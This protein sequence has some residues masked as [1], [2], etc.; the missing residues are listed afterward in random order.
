M[1]PILQIGAMAKHGFKGNAALSVPCGLVLSAGS[2]EGSVP[3]CREII[4]CMCYPK[5]QD[6]GD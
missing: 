3:Y 5:R 6:E 1:S 4:S 2:I